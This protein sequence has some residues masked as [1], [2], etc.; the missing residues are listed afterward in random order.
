[1]CS[2]GAFMVPRYFLAV[3]I[4]YRGVGGLVPV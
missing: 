1:M 4:G 3:A 2:W